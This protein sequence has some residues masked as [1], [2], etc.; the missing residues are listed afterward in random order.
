[1]VI[2]GGKLGDMIR[3]F[4]VVHRCRTCYETHHCRLR[5]DTKRCHPSE[6]YELVPFK[7]NVHLLSTI[8][9]GLS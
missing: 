1:M 6:P 3:G 4:I 8:S 7:G 9:T 2:C 5:S